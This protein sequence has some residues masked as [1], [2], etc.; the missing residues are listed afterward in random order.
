MIYWDPKRTLI[1]HMRTY[2]GLKCVLHAF[3]EL[4]VDLDGQVADHRS[5]LSQVKVGQTVLVLPGSVVLH[6][7]LAGKNN[8]YYLFIF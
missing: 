5:V 8:F 2:H 6:E 3:D 7:D 4:L 1:W